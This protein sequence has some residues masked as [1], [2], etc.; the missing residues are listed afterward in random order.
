MTATQTIVLHAL[1]Q[2]RCPV[3]T[4]VISGGAYVVQRLPAATPVDAAHCTVRE[5]ARTHAGTAVAGWVAKLCRL[6]R[7]ETVYS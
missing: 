5:L 4:T 1:I 7:A 6:K 3:S 2:Q